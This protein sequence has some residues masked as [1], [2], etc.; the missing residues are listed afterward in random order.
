MN[1]VVIIMNEDIEFFWKRKSY[2][3]EEMEAYIEDENGWN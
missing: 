3:E 2:R 1:N